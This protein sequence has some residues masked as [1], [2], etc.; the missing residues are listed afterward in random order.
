[1]HFELVLSLQWKRRCFS[2]CE[3]SYQDHAN[4]IRYILYAASA[5]EWR[6]Q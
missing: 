3:W 1:M 6:D 5:T 4:Y 2:I